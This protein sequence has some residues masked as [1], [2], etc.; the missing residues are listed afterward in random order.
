MFNDVYSN[1][2]Y[3]FVAGGTLLL[4]SAC[5]QTCLCGGMPV[6]A[7]PV[8]SE[9]GMPL[10]LVD[11]NRTYDSARERNVSFDGAYRPEYDANTYGGRTA[12]IVDPQ[13][14]A[15]QSRREEKEEKIKMT[16]L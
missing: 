8:A 5:F 2:S 14:R 11:V 10:G 16:A 3:F 15:W 9:D 1:S 6:S 12:E 13:Y 4:V 7:R